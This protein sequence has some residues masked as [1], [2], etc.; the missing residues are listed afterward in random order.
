METLAAEDGSR[1]TSDQ[2]Q[3]LDHLLLVKSVDKSEAAH[4]ALLTFTIAFR[5]V[6]LTP[7][8]NVVI[9]DSLHERLRYAPKSATC[10]HEADVQTAENEVG[11]TRL[12]WTLKKALAPGE[13]GKVTFQARVMA[14]PEAEQR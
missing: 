12:R 11:S 6:E 2:A 14:W 3:R 7:I 8:Q 5:N 4:G 9:V 13:Q 1:T 10:T